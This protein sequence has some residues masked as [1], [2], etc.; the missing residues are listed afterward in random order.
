MKNNRNLDKLSEDLSN[1]LLPFIEFKYRKEI[2][3]YIFQ[4]YNEP[5]HSALHSKEL[6]MDNVIRAIW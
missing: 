5:V 1:N 3:A 6:L 2:D 4:R